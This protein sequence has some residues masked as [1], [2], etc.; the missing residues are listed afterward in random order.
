MS[1]TTQKIE[2]LQKVSNKP[3]IEQLEDEI[4]K[5]K[6]KSDSDTYLYGQGQS[7]AYGKVLEL[8]D[9]SHIR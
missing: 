2:K 6:R 4:R 5:L 3:R 9:K 1:N 7:L 8:L